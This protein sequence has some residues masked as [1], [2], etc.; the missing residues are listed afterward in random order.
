MQEADREHVRRIAA[1]IFG[2]ANDLKRTPQALAR[3]LGQPEELVRQ[4]IAGEAD[5]ESAEALLRAIAAEY[6]ISL[7]DL[8][9]ERDDTHSGVHIMSAADSAAS[10]R[11]FDRKDRHGALA[12]YYDY[13]DT[14]MSRGGP[15]KPEWIMP[16][17]VAADSDPDNPDIAY[18]NGH[19]LCQMTFF[20]GE[21]NF[22]WTID[23]KNYSKEMNTGDTNYITPFVPHS[24][25][26]R[27]PDS[28]GLIIAVTFS[29]EV[30]RALEAFRILGADGADTLAGDLRDPISAFSALIA[31][32]RNAESLSESDLAARL[33]EGGVPENRAAKIAAGL[34]VAQPP[35]IDPLARALN[36]RPQ[37]LMLSTL[38]PSEEVVIAKALSCE[39]RAFPGDNR[40]QYRLTEL[41]RTKHQPELKGFEITVLGEDVARG[42][43]CHGL[44]EYV[45]NYGQAPVSLWWGP[46]HTAVLESGDS[47]YVQPMVQHGFL[48]PAAQPE[49]HLAVV[50]VPGGASKSVLT[51][52][53]GY[54]PA[55][56][57]RVAGESILWF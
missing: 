2:E 29:G 31:R 34:D 7:A 16:L 26:S 27:N 46:D 41:A 48:R 21:V 39:P 12:P 53:A 55:G 52:Y 22:Y 37:D 40:P 1:R 44:H 20:V 10:S 5:V 15:Y 45:Y 24:F 50:R 56:R 18:N 14:A 51:E 11:V 6:P 32:N 4:V 47:A 35:E 42:T 54:A 13:R 30:R 25:A 19:L 43:L 3:E 49:G 17:R 8:W 23:G 36:I 38:D 33:I 57:V 28:L 9:V